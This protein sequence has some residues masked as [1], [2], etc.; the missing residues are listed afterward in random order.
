MAGNQAVGLWLK[1]KCN[2]DNINE[3][4][5]GMLFVKEV[6]ETNF[7]SSLLFSIL[8]DVVKPLITWKPYWFGSG[9]FETIIKH[10]GL[11]FFFSKV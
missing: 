9:Q 4:H 2:F 11:P 10:F 5:W 7:H 8:F 3:Y 1:N 6:F